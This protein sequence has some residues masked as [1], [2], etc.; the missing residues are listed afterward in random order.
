MAPSM[1]TCGSSTQAATGG[2]QMAPAVFA[3]VN[4]PAVAAASLAVRGSASPTSVNSAPDRHDTGSVSTT[5]NQSTV[6]HSP[7]C[8]PDVRRPNST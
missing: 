6:V 7:T 2:P 4:R 3:S 1:P 8:V 5:A